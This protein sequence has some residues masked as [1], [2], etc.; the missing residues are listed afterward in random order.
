MLDHSGPGSYD[1]YLPFYES[2]GNHNYEI[3]YISSDSHPSLSATGSFNVIYNIDVNVTDAY[4]GAPATIRVN[5]P[6]G[7]KKENVTI[8]VNGNQYTASIKDG[9][10]FSDWKT[11]ENTITAT[12]E[13]DDSF[14]AKSVTK[15]VNVKAKIQQSKDEIIYNSTEA[16]YLILPD[17]ATGKLTVSKGESIIDE[18]TVKGGRN[19]WI[20]FKNVDLGLNTL[21]FSYDG[22][23][24]ADEEEISFNLLANISYPRFMY[25][26]GPENLTITAPEKSNGTFSVKIR[27]IQSNSSSQEFIYGDVTFS[28]SCNLTNGKA[29]I[30][31]KDIEPGRQ[32]LFIEYNQTG[33]SYS[34]TPDIFVFKDL[35]NADLTVTANDI[36]VG[37]EA[38][39]EITINP[40]ASG[41]VTLNIDGENHTVNI[42]NGHGVLE[43]SG[44]GLG[45]HNVRATYAGDENFTNDEKTH[46]F[47]VKKNPNLEISAGDIHVGD[48]AT[49]NITIDSNITDGVNLTV[50]GKPYEVKLSDGRATVTISDLSADA[51][52]VKAIFAGNDNFT[53]D[54]KTKTFN[55][56]KYDAGLEVT[57]KDI[58]YGENATLLIKINENATGEVT[59]SFKNEILPVSLSKGMANIILNGLTA[60]T[61]SIAVTFDG[62]SKFSS[63]EMNVTFR[64]KAKDALVEAPEIGIV[65][66]GDEIIIKF[67]SDAKGSVILSTNKAN[68]TFEVKDGKAIVKIPDLANGNFQYSLIYTGD[69]NYSSKTIVN[70]TF[71]ID[72]PT[73]KPAEKQE[74]KVSL[75]LKKVKVKKSAKK[76]VIQATLKI[77]GKPVKGKM[78]KF[79]FNGKTYKAKTNKK[80]VAKITIKKNFL[81]KLKVGKKVKIQVTYLKTTKKL[82]V[83]VKK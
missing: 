1:L 14:P 35:L 2:C 58:T 7:V 29:T 6:S 46:I 83:M 72:N 30:T 60:G 50:N 71:R 59:Y 21:K 36:A 37:E 33:Y 40:N 16:V 31:L 44:L 51:Y 79:K 20:P 78:V 10:T 41:D 26:K 54:A 55:V 81:K 17:D 28:H 74:N 67:P 56:L 25:A 22:N 42:T 32:A 18:I 52:E 64:V 23:Y 11:G 12:Y 47:R 4:Y 38:R 63:D 80:G 8:T 69:G 13:G 53:S 24:M 39:V 65:K 62:D 19:V 5:L 76:L 68:Y 61:Y 45:E 77:N 49:I 15:T 43:L 66:T 48:A 57:V 70:A 9:L 75:V 3:K 82:S 73:V 34:T 27:E